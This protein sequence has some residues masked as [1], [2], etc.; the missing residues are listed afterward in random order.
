MDEA[1]FWR[2]I[3]KVFYI[4]IE[5]FSNFEYDELQDQIIKEYLAKGGEKAIIDFQNIL[6]EKIRALYLPKIG[7]L[8]LLTVYDLE[9]EMTKN[10]KYISTDG[11]LDFRA[12]IVSLGE[13]HYNIFRNF[14]SESELFDYDLNP[15][16]ATRELL[17]FLGQQI[18]RNLEIEIDLEFY[19]DNDYQELYAK[20][21]WE[22]LNEK[23]PKLCSL[24]QKRFKKGRYE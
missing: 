5:D 17:V 23:Y 21:Q 1:E 14:E 13:R 9:D 3:E 16:Y 22:N 7:E 11:F 6:G 18:A 4:P 24:Y 2:L 15:N 19:F 12:W 8:F 10:F 20:M